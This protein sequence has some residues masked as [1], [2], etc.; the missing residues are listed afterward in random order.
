MSTKRISEHDV[1]A[2][3]TFEAASYWFVKHDAGGMTAQDRL[4]FDRWL[5]SSDNHR[6]IYEQ[7]T[8]MWTD[9][10]DAADGSELRALRVAALASDPAPS[11]WLRATAIAAGLVAGIV[12]IAALTWHLSGRARL[13]EISTSPSAGNQY[14]TA[15]NQRSTVT[16]ADGTL[17]SMNLDTSFKTAFSSTQRLIYL[18]KGQVF[19]EVAK[20]PARPFIVIAGDRRIQALGTKFDVKLDPTRLEVVLV[21]GRV[22]VDK[23]EP[24]LMAR[25]TGRSARVELK[26]NQKLVANDNEAASITSTNALHA[27]SW[28]EG[29]IVFEDETVA[30]AIAELNRYSDQ[31]IVAT[32]ETVRQ[33][34]LSGVFRI[35]QPERF[36]AVIQELLPLEVRRGAQG[37]ILLMPKAN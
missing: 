24:S 8:A 36:S 35:G 20:N 23:N 29:W 12:A 30:R 33:M 9:V 28:R 5:A 26:P 34:R 11:V 27:T 10:E 31:P 18:T 13:D 25:V 37:E 4:E 1:A 2:M 16:L 32:D 17:V 21:E 7:T 3:T 6:K 14:V 19:F 22:S 15:H